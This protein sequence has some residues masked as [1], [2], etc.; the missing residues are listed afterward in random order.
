MIYLI[1]HGQTEWNK[2]KVMQGRTDIPLNE[3]GISQAKT[4]GEKIKNVKFAKV[5]CSPLLRARQTFENLGGRQCIDV[6]YDDRL[7]ERN[8]GEFEKTEKSSFDYNL[9]WN[10]TKN[11]KYKRAECAK[12]FFDRVCD[13][14]KMLENEYAEKDVLVVTHAG[15]TKVFKWYFDGLNDEEIGPYL[16]NNCDV[17][18]Y[19][20]E[21]R[22]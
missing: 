4:L 1:R 9:F 20:T 14:I 22:K 13:F 17:L 19:S 18:T 16:P 7:L 8:Y 15:V 6:V 10:L 12:D 2:L 5:F 21:K 3:V 11:V